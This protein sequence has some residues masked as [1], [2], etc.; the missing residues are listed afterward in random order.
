MISLDKLQ[1]NI[2]RW[3]LLQTFTS[4]PFTNYSLYVSWADCKK[5]IKNISTGY[6]SVSTRVQ[7]NIINVSFGDLRNLMV[8]ENLRFNV[9]CG[10]ISAGVIRQF[11]LPRNE[12]RGAVYV[13]M[14][15]YRH[16]LD[17]PFSK[18]GLHDIS[19]HQSLNTSIMVLCWQLCN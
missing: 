18:M 17:I 10:I 1:R 13:K 15:Y 14:L 4:I 11:L 9:W 7:L 5:A 3:Y 16:Q 8:W 19:G 2:D 12:K 6:T